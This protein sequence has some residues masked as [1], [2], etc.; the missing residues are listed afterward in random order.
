MN[1]R[2]FIFSTALFSFVFLGCAQTRALEKAPQKNSSASSNGGDVTATLTPGDTKSLMYTVLSEISSLQPY[3]VNE[4]KFLDPKNESDIKGHIENLAKLSE[5]VIKNKKLQTPSYRLS[6]EA[7][8][9]HFNELKYAFA[10]GNKKYARW[11]LSATPYACA[12]CHT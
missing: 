6:G 11:M 5:K 2:Q 8:D 7:I 12:S 1:V 4:Q 10:S 9:A 3:M